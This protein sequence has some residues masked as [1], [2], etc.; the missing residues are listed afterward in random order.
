MKVTLGP[1]VQKQLGIEPDKKG[2]LVSSDDFFKKLQAKEKWYSKRPI[3]RFFKD[4]WWWIRYG[5]LNKISDIKCSIKW[6]FQRMFRGYD[7]PMVWGYW[8][9]NAKLNVTLLKRLKETKI[10]YPIIL[11]DKQEEKKFGKS[12]GKHDKSL[13]K[14]YE[15]RW[16]ETMD[17]I[18]A[19]W[20]AI[21]DEDDVFLKTNG[22]YDHAKSDI[23]RKKLMKAFEEGMTLYTKHYRGLWD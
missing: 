22:K 1:V 16:D 15:K 11:L 23:K 20:Q 4:A 14:M 10:G 12:W 19:G 8:H 9:E 5:I 18:I 17:K 6:G 7:D 21:I 3:R 13:H 2:S